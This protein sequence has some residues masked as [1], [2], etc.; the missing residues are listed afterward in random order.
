MRLGGSILKPYDSSEKWFEEVKRL[1]YS[2][3]IAPFDHNSSKSEIEAY[4]K[5]IKENDLILG[6]VGAW[7]NP[8]SLD[9]EER[10][11]NI[12][13]CQEQLNLADEYGANCC[14]NI[15]GGTGETWDGCYLENYQ[16]DTYALIVDRI[17]EIIDGVNPKNTYYTIEPMPWM[18]PDSPEQYLKLIKDVDRERFAVHMDYTNMINTPSKYVKS[19]EFIKHCYKLLGPYIKSVHIKDVLMSSQLPCNI[20]E[21]LP[22]QGRIDLGQV[23]KLT[24]QLNGNTTAYLEHFQHDEEYV[25]GMQYMK[26]IANEVGISIRGDEK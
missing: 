7:S 17:R 15:V 9:P 25:I 26:Q 23:L 1:G 6:E 3:V 21:V 19:S 22:G 20:R 8:M 11:K 2:C 24:H 13:Y 5:L 10:Q 14:V 16:E 4:M 18:V 12:R